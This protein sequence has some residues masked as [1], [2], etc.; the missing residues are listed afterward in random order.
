MFNS[1]ESLDEDPPSLFSTE[2]VSSQQSIDAAMNGLYDVWHND[3][4]AMFIRNLLAEG[5]MPYTK[6]RL[7]GPSGATWTEYSW[8]PATTNFLE[9]IW[10]RSYTM[11]GISNSLLD[12]IPGKLEVDIEE[13][14]LAEARFHRADMYFLLVRTYG[15]VP[16]H[17]ESTTDIPID[18]TS[19]PRNKEEEVYAAIIED[20]QFAESRLPSRDQLPANE[21]GRP[22]AGAAKSLLGEVYLQMAG[23]NEQGLLSTGSDGYTLAEAKLLE[24]VNSNNYGLP[25]IQDVFNVTNEWNSDIVHAYS[26]VRNIETP[27]LFPWAFG[28]PNSP[29]NG[30]LNSFLQ[31]GF[32]QTY[33]DSFDVNDTRRDWLAY[34]YIDRNGD[35]ITYNTPND[36]IDL[37]FVSSYTD[38]E[39]GMSMIKYSDPGQGNAPLT[40]ATDYV[41]IRYADVLLMLAEAQVKLGKNSL[42]LMNINKVRFRAGVDDLDAITLDNIKQ[43]RQWELGLEFQGYYDLQRWG[44]VKKAFDASPAAKDTGTVWHDGL[45]RM[46]L[47]ANTL[48]ANTNLVQNPG[49]I[50][51]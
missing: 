20:L 21:N 39:T 10:N 48:T 23:L 36:G 16:L 38:A 51:N 26:V 46:P 24:V 45:I 33:Y 4:G 6:S 8:N 28:P 49:Y 44:D 14:L 22:T 50:K 35:V 27:T 31:F 37:G 5:P 42:A 17:L 7:A 18:G 29:Y 32:L 34:E 3:V 11:I 25:N 43:E 40:H 19:L 30:G 41:F 9:T 15:G 47:H 12:L 2:S 1:C 13:R